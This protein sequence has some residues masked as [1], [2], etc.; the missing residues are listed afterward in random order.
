MFHETVLQDL[1][2]SPSLIIR[3]FT[4]LVFVKSVIHTLIHPVTRSPSTLHIEQ[5]GRNDGN[6]GKKGT[7][8]QK[9]R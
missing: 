6:V 5:L 4:S 2:I 8:K 3:P 1:S 7:R 9:E